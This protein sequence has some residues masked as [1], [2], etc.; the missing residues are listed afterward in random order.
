MGGKSWLLEYKLQSKQMYNI[1]AVYS[2][3]WTYD[4]GGITRWC[5]LTDAVIGLKR[6]V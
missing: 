4:T 6:N 1:K 5:L 2:L 3:F